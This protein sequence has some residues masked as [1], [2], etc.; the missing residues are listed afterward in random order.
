VK[1]K[2]KIVG[3]KIGTLRTP[4]YKMTANAP[5]WLWTQYYESKDKPSFTLAISEDGESMSLLFE[6]GRTFFLH[7]PEML[8]DLIRELE[9]QKAISKGGEQHHEE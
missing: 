1:G 9:E 6:H 8:G 7:L 4:I 3:E 2:K 5:V